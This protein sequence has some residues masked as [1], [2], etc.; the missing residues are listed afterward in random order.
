MN[1]ILLQIP[2]AVAEQ[3]KVVIIQK[4][5]Q[6]GVNR[7]HFLVNIDAGAFRTGVMARSK[8]SG[9]LST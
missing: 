7:R 6:I 5:R 3:R 9:L 4:T 2:S 8:M 1:M